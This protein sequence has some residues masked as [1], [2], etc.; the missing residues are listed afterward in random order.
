MGVHIDIRYHHGA[1]VVALAG[2][3]D[4]TGLSLWAE[5]LGEA[6]AAEVVVADVDQARFADQQALAYL[7]GVLGDPRRP[8]HLRVVARRSSL[9][10]RL[11]TWKVHHR[12]A[13]HPNIKDALA[14][15]LGQR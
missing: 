6:A 15:G 9:T 12:V 2:D 13:I 1:A 10:A 8:G 4:V 5:Q 11:V 7:L 3:A 14:A